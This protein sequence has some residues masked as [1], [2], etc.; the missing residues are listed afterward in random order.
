MTTNIQH[1]TFLIKFRRDST[2]WACYPHPKF[3]TISITGDKC[4]LNCK[5]CGRHY[6]QNMLACQTPDIL[7]KTCLELASNGVHGVLLSGGYNED[8][9]VPFAPFLDTIEQ[10]KNDTGL[11]LSAHTGLVPNWIARE[12]G[13]VGVDL[14]DFDLIGDDETIKLVLGIDRKVEDY[15]TAMKALKRSLPHVVPHICIGL[16]AGEIKGERVALELAADITPQALV[17]LVLVPTPRTEFEHITGPSPAEVGELIAEARLKFP[18]ATLALGCMRP[19]D[20]RRVEF[21]LQALHAGVDRMELPSEQTT[22]AARKLGLQVQRIEACCS[23]SS[24]FTGV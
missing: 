15:R 3:P 1:R 2:F 21:E 14:A 12:L 8:G 23:V 6:L 24:S 16:H 18:E 17:M 7:R 9:Y 20:A 19:R 10:V 22:E 11:F 4:A 13:R 5:H